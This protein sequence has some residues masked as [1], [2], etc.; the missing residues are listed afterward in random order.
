L[1]TEVEKRD[2]APSLVRPQVGLMLSCGEAPTSA[3]GYPKK[4][5]YIRPKPGA[6]GQFTENA[7]RFTEV[8]GERPREIDIVFV[9]DRIA[10]V[11]DVRPKVW[12]TGGLKA[13]GKDN[14]AALPG[15]EFEQAVRAYDWE[16]TTFPDDSPEPGSYTVAGRDDKAVTKLNLKVYGTLRV[17]IPKV[18]GLMMLAEVSTTSLR[19]ISNWHNAIELA[20]RITGGVLVGI[21]FK[22]ILRPARTRYFDKK[23]KKRRSSEFQEW[24]LESVHTLDELYEIAGKRRQAVTAGAPQAALP[25]VR[26][27]NRDRDEELAQAL[28]QRT[29]EEREVVEQLS[30]IPSPEAEDVKLRDEPN[31]EERPSD[32]QLNRLADLERRL[33]G[34]HEPFLVGAFGVDSAEK[35]TAAQ[36]SAYEQGL[37]RLVEAGGPAEEGEVVDAEAEEFTFE[38]PESARK[39][40]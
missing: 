26:H 40:S 20:T 34:E 22:L 35:L 6:L 3:R 15:D 18:T 16:L 11:L 4:L 38:V 32:A 9:S 5:D 23:E 17:S 39:P 30:G 8:Y 24:T 37:A 14:L 2:A 21:P 27:D 12:G 10:D 25:P 36:A 33:G 1:S 13:V 7:E 31:A 29:A 28:W 19:T